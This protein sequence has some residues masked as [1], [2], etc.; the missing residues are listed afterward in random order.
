MSI[1]TVT[2]KAQITI[3]KEIRER[4]NITPGSKLRFWENSQGELMVTPMT[5]RVEETFRWADENLRSPVTRPLTIEELNDAAAQAW[6]LGE[7][8][9]SEEV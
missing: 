2:S 5:V 8:D 6:A 7:P 9:D 3:P 1:A 4:Y